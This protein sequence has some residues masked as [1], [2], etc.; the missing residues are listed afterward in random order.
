MLDGPAAACVDVMLDVINVGSLAISHWKRGTKDGEMNRNESESL[1]FQVEVVTVYFSDRSRSDI[2]PAHHVK[3]R[4]TVQATSRAMQRPSASS[5]PPRSPD[6]PKDLPPRAAAE[7]T[8][9]RLG[10]R[11]RRE[12]ISSLVPLRRAGRLRHARYHL[13]TVSTSRSSHVQVLIH[14]LEYYYSLQTWPEPV[15]TPLKAAL[16]AKNRGDYDRAEAYFRK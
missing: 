7:A 8:R 2:I 6:R 10:C 13:W 15:R 9:L 16:K 11:T 4:R 14:R 3:H 5:S 1:D 12:G